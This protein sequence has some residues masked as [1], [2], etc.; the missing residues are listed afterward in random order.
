MLV[1]LYYITDRR[2]FSG[3]ESAQRR[4]LLAKIAEA[5]RCGADYIQLREKDLSPRD[6]ESLARE[7]VEVVRE[8]SAQSR[9][10]TP[11]TG[12]APSL[13]TNHWPLATRL[14]IN[15]RLDVAL[16]CGADG[17]HLPG[18][19]IFA[20]DARALWDVAARNLK[21]ESR[22]ALIALSCHSLA[23]VLAAE[24][25]GADFAVFGPVFEKVVAVR[26][27]CES[28][29]SHPERSLGSAPR[30]GVGVKALGEIC[31]R[32]AP[33]DRKT[34]SAPSGRMPV[35]ALGGVTLK[36][37]RACLQAG[38]AGIAG[39]RLFQENDISEVIAVL[40]DRGLPDDRRPATD[41]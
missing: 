7:A 9:R 35:L 39:I 29:G 33:R 4:A 5:A 26:G 38:A 13:A 34:E 28:R 14:L 32:G 18:G 40:R 2:Q 24:A 22:N 30:P 6:L 10:A 25:H 31:R 3:D 17:V 19:D 36:N 23:E 16:A 8:N 37:A 12:T 41:D 11:E 27:G 1:L 20:A 15:S 21:R